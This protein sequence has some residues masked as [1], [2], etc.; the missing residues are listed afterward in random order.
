LE[1]IA[2]QESTYQQFFTKTLYGVSA[3]WP[4]ESYD[5]GSHIGLMQVPAT[6][7]NAFDWLQNTK[8]GSVVFLNAIK[9]SK[10]EEAL[11][12]ASTPGLPAL[13]P[14][15]LENMALSAYTIGYKGVTM[16]YYIPDSSSGTPQWVENT[17]NDPVGTQYADS[18]RQ[19]V[20]PP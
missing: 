3:L 10:S 4:H 2:M 6:M 17:V 19:Q 13:T 7:A 1:Q 9:Y 12:H 18:V 14:V 11:I 15:Q 5:G 8:A 20:P 16:Q